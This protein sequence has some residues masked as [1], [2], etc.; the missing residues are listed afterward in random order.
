[1]KSTKKALVLSLLS[2]VVCASL[3]VGTTFAWFTDSVT[4]ANNIIKSGNLDVELYYSNAVTN[5]A[6][7]EVND[8]TNVFKDDTLWEP[9]HTEVVKFK[10]VNAGTLALKYKLGVNIV[11]EQGS[12]N[13]NDEAFKLSD[14]IYF[15]VVNGDN[16][17]TRE[18][19]VAAVSGSATT[20]A[21]SFAKYSSIEDKDDYEI[22]T[23]VVYMPETVGNEANYKKG[24]AVPT[25]DL[26][27]NLIATQ[28]AS[29][30]D[31]FDANY[32]AA[33]ELPGSGS[34]ALA[35]NDS[36]VVVE[37]R[38]EADKK[39]G[40]AVVPAG[41]IADPT[42]PVEVFV[43]ESA[44]EANITVA[45]DLETVAFEVSITNFKPD[46]EFVKVTLNLPTG[47][48][49][50]TF[51]LYHY[52]TEIPC[53]YDPNTGLVT[54]ESKT[55]SPFTVVYDAESVYVPV[56][57]ET[58]YTDLPEADVTEYTDTE[59]IEWGNYGQWSP[60]E[61]LEANL[62]AAY[63][64]KVTQTAEQVESSPY[65]FWHC[66]FYVMLDKDLGEN[67]IFLGGNYGS[68]GW[69][70][71]HN[72]DV[73][74]KANEALPLLGSVTQNPWTYEDIADF[75]D[76]FVC[77]VGDVDGALAEKGATFTVMLRLTNPENENE[78]VDVVTITYN[79]ATE[80]SVVSYYAAQ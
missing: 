68:F 16:T 46:Q 3:L 77:G 28:F 76:T 12:V 52:D 30:T 65:R 55:F 60:T 67:E 51:K 58:G 40:S 34:A 7:V 5:G 10:V 26:G 32:D 69:I 21:N 23:M 4:S 53:N 17:Y 9:G 31:S 78:Y 56:T 57:P 80:K 41:A 36:A 72:G 33:A 59:N 43:D 63:Q 19:A 66:D 70:G 54:F 25:I 22:V 64:F 62:E 49:P 38:N 24:E 42:K 18:E 61:G 20:I 15:G 48:D 2:L 44:Y 50:S 6:W 75:V 73:T 47:K 39:V 45:T 14:Y 27:V 79:F 8:Q 35:P 74:L 29:E 37:I 11:S 13:V 1:M 71:F